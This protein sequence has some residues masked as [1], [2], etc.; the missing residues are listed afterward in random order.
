MDVAKDRND[1]T[2]TLIN[3]N[4]LENVNRFTYLGSII[5][6]NGD[7]APEL[8]NHIGNTANAFNRLLPFIRHKS[9]KM[10]TKITI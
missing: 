5:T 10:R 1:I 3:Q 2:T 6:H 9:I 8:D 4:S 7:L